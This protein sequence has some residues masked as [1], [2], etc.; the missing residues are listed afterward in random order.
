MRQFSNTFLLLFV[1][2]LLPSVLFKDLIGQEE[3]WQEQKYTVQD[4]TNI[5]DKM[6]ARIDFLNKESEKEK[7][8]N[9]LKIANF[10][11]TAQLIKAINAIK[12]A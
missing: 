4:L 5:F 2:S 1:M 3:L 7:K 6:K 8:G 11:N 10:K 12:E 9:S